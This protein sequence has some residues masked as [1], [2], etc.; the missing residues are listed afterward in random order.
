MTGQLFTEGA[1]FGDPWSSHS[2]MPNQNVIRC[3]KVS[4]PPLPSWRFSRLP[5]A[6]ERG[7]VIAPPR[8]V[9]LWR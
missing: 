1:G 7:E 6:I 9:R 4:L 8:L 3:W 2:C 5:A